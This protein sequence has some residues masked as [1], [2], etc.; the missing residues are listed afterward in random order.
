[1]AQVAPGVVPQGPVQ[2]QSVKGGWGVGGALGLGVAERFSN[3][4]ASAHAPLVPAPLTAIAD[5]AVDGAQQAGA[6][7][8]REQHRGAHLDGAGGGGEGFG[9][10]DQA[11]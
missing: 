9:S 2:G 7:R 4:N 11:V 1:M 5:G 6:G 3:A 8:E 10:L